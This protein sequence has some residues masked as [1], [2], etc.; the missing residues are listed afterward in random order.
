MATVPVRTEDLED[1][2]RHLQ[3]LQETQRAERRAACMRLSDAIVTE[4][5]YIADHAPGADT[6]ASK[7]ALEDALSSF[8]DVVLKEE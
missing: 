5:A 3:R 7:K 2:I 6:E 1:L 4:A 8:L